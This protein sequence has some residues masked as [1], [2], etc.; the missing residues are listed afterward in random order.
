[1]IPDT[2]PGQA[3]GQKIRPGHATPLEKYGRSDDDDDVFAFL[4]LFLEFRGRRSIVSRA[5]H[6][7]RHGNRC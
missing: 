2:F 4:R 7:I 1:M 6:P 3:V 5:V